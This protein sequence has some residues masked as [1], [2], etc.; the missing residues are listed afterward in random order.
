MLG[1]TEEDKY[2]A[3]LNDVLAPF[4]LRLENGTA[5]DYERAGEPPDW[6][7]AQRAPGTAAP[8]LLHL[9]GDV[10]FYRAGIVTA[11]DPG[12]IV[13]RA[14]A[15]VEPP[16]AGL[17]AAASHGDGRVVVAADSDLFGDAVLGRHDHRQLWLNIALLGRPR[18]LPRRARP[19]GRRRPARIPPGS[20][21]RTR[22]TRC[23]RCRTP[24]ARSTWRV[25]ARTPHAP[26]SRR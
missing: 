5:L 21:S 9:A 8:E 3:N 24:R 13:L 18:R 22:P 2:G 16:A 14:G 26:T 12:A 4:G 19:L 25:M 11:D 10:V 6:I 23:A 17:L 20:A 1:E 7:G 15:E